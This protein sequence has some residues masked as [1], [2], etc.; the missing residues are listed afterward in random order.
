MKINAHSLCLPFFWFLTTFSWNYLHS[1]D[2]I[3]F[4]E[5]V[6]YVA[7]P[8]T[9]GNAQAQA[10]FNQ[11]LTFHYAYNQNAAYKSF[12]MAAELDPEMGM[13]YWGMALASSPI[14]AVEVS[15]SQE[16][17]GYEAIQKAIQL[18]SKLPEVE[19]AY[20]HALAQRFTNDPKPNFRQLENN[21]MVAQKKVM[22]KYPDDLDA[23]NLFAESALNL[24]PENLWKTN[25]EPN[26]GTKEIID[27]LISVIKRDPTNIGGNHFYIHA[28]ENSQYAERALP[29]ADAVAQVAPILSHL[30]HSSS[31]IYLKLGYYQKSI[32][33]NRKAILGDRVY[34]ESLGPS[35]NVYRNYAHNLHYLVCSYAMAGNFEEALKNG[36]DLREVFFGNY[37]HFEKLELYYSIPLFVLIC[38]EK[39]ELILQEK[40]PPA[41]LKNSQALWHYARAISFAALGKRDQALVEKALILLPKEVNEQMKDEVKLLEFFLYA[42]IAESGNDLISAINYYQKAVN[43][44][45]TLENSQMDYLLIW[46][47]YLGRALLKNR[48]YEEAEKVFRDDLKKHARNGRSL[49]GLYESLI[50]QARAYDA[51]WVK[52]E[53]DLAWKY[54]D[55]PKENHL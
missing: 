9:T 22:E 40:I 35:R 8:V 42:K 21:F 55:M 41:F 19:K 52:R 50:S 36:N 4:F 45:D 6:I 17:K 37:S 47:E 18:S 12:K 11:G 38:F 24:N 10:Y 31:H 7:H 23:A 43:L 20:I 30:V 33:V 39:W 48:Q 3:P 29:S 32:D 44:D 49:L 13:A 2:Y 53:F 15:L 26:E 54:S 25:G 51:F 34:I 28:L 5:N 14:M 46:R 1:L 27:S 16:N